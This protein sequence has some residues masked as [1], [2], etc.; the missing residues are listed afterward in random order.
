MDNKENLKVALVSLYPRFADSILS[1]EKKVEFR[2]TRMSEEISSVIIYSTSPVKKVVG[3]FEV[4]EIVSKKPLAL[5]RD[6]K[7]SSGLEFREYAEYYD[8]KKEAFGIVVGNVV[9]LETPLSLEELGLTGPPP[10]SFRYLEWN[11]VENRLVGNR[12]GLIQRFKSAMNRF[13]EL[14]VELAK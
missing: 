6:F 10:Q 13:L 5:W 7:N 9:R 14:R 1:G 2:K 4:K 8:G 3:Y 11:D 12:F